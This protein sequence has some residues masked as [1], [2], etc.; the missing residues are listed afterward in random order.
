MILKALYEYYQRDKNSVP[1]GWMWA[2]LSFIIV[3]DEKGHYLGIEDCRNEKGKGQPFLLPKGEHNNSETPLLYWDN[4]MYALDYSDKPSITTHNK[5]LSFVK[6]CK[7][8]ANKYKFDS[9]QSVVLFYEQNELVKVYQDPLW[10]TIIKNPNNNVSF[11]I[12]GS[13]RIVPCEDTFIKIVQSERVGNEADTKKG[14]CLVTGDYSTLVKTGTKTPIKGCKSS[15]KLVS[16]QVSSGYDSYGKEQC[17]NAPISVEADF[18][19]S[20][21]IK[22]ML[23]ENSRNKYIIGNRTFLF[24]ASKDDEAGQKAEDSFF[25]LFGF[26]EQKDDPNKNIEQVRKVFEAIYKG[27]LKTNLEDTFYILGLAPN[28]ARIAV[29]YWAEIPLRKFAETICKHFDD[30]EVSDTRIE[31]KPYMSLRNIISTV[32]LGGNV[33]DATPNLADTVAKSIFEGLPYPQTLFASCIRRI[34][35]ESGEKDKNAIQITRAA[36]IKAYLNRLNNKEQKIKVMLD[37]DNTNQGYLYGR[38]F[39]VLDKIQEEA[40][41]QH[42]IRERYM[43]SASSTPA[44]VFSTILNLSNHHIE[45]LKN[46]GRK[47]HFEKLKQE[48]ISKIDADGFK[49]QLDLQD[50]GRFFIGYYHQRQDFFTNNIE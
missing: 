31:K 36:I 21:A 10:E 33:S 41:N 32:T 5:H 4:L 8:V 19:F 25:S 17:Y 47:I 29:T 46:E 18:A 11:K 16:F 2:N 44:T 9:L 35:A 45:N 13:M 43:N 23:D 15:A 38:L 1:L 48:I 37:K 20:S 26:N 50:Q 28:A 42:S 24:W 27:S 7:D 22:K 12:Q 14:I 49:A 39:A 6:R 40:N 34:R 30:M 3:I